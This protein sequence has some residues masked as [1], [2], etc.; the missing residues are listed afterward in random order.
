MFAN[1]Y[2]L[3]KM[4]TQLIIYYEKILIIE[5]QYPEWPAIKVI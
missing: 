4:A 2:H 5:T 1:L 3:L